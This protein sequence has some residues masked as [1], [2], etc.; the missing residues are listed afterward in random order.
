M[1]K[2]GASTY[3]PTK[4][5][6]LPRSKVLKLKEICTPPEWKILLIQSKLTTL[7]INSGDYN[8]ISTPYG[9]SELSTQSKFEFDFFPTRNCR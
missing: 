8:N 6:T 1:G 9:C 5:G 3:K 7:N 2:G 4:F